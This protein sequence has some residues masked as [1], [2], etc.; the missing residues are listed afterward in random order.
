MRG[1][2][3]RV[4]ADQQR[5]EGEAAAQELILDE[6]RDVAVDAQIRLQPDQVGR[7]LEHVAE[8]QE[9]LV[10]QLDK[11]FSKMALVVPMKRW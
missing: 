2:I 6:L 5:V 4:A 10:G 7:D 9:R 8:V 1:R 11:P 3:E